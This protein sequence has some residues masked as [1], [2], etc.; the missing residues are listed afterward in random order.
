M[1]RIN[2]PPPLIPTF[3]GDPPDAFQAPAGFQWGPPPR[4]S[5]PN[6]QPERDQQ[7]T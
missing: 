6:N 2:Q 1:T 5:N 7:P 3:E 4:P